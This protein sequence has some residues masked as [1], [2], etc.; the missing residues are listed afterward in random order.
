MEAIEQKIINDGLD[1]P[2][3]YT[4][5]GEVPFWDHP[6][7]KGSKVLPQKYYPYTTVEGA[8]DLFRR[9][10]VDDTDFTLLKVLGD[11]ICANEDQIRRYMESVMTRSE[12]SKR[13]E[14][15]RSTGLVERWKVRVRG[16]EETYKPPAPF[17][18]G[19]AGYKLL[20][21]FYSEDYF[22]D[23]N[24]WDKQG[25]GG[26]KRFV[27]MNELRCLMIEQKIVS[28][29]KWNA[30]IADNTKLKFPLAAAEVK[31]PQGKVNFLI[32]RA[33]MN[34][35]FIGYFR[36]KL[37]TWK[38]VYEKFGTIPV[39][40]FPQNKMT[41]VVL[42][43]STLTVAEYIHKELML[44]TYPFPIWLCVEEDMLQDCLNK[45]FYVT[46]KENL[47]RIQVDF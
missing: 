23:P 31:T 3:F 19:V 6:F 36:D 17:T 37:T 42:Y 35:N 34:Q 24:R 47:K 41:F 8:L 32:D 11:A 16:Q 25:I 46:N 5:K 45:S 14:R 20:K 2:Y 10:R 18:L 33:Q 44:D 27:A 12:T 26:M 15:F 28:K 9:G 39:S 29:W 22:M 38:R 13:L 43:T 4:K 7:L 30:V 21:H 40:E 1:Y